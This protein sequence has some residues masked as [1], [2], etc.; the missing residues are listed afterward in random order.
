MCNSAPLIR[1]D[2]SAEAVI[3]FVFSTN[4]SSFQA[5]SSCQWL[6]ETL[7]TYLPTAA[8]LSIS[9][10]NTELTNMQ[11]INHYFIHYVCS[12]HSQIQRILLAH[13][14]VTLTWASS[15]FHA[16]AEIYL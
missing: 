12:S 7:F 9:I 11:S 15:N 5:I 1:T 2:F 6:E 13:T 16:F 4:L 10:L 8:V 14:D 3:F